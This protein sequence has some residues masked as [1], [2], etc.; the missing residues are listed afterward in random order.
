MAFNVQSW[1]RISS[2]S[3]NDI[4]TLQDGSFV[5]APNIFTYISATD[6]LATIAASGYFN[7]V[8]F[9]MNVY[10]YIQVHGTDG[11][12]ELTVATITAATPP[13]V[14]TTSAGA[15]GD[16][17]GPAVSINNNLVAFDGVT[18]KLIKD[19][20]Q[21]IATIQN[22]S[23]VYAASAAGTDTYAV[24]LA[25][26]PTAY[27]NGMVV[28]FKTDVANTGAATLNVNG[29]GAVSI[30]KTNGTALAT[31][32]IGATHIATVVYNSTGPTFQLQSPVANSVSGI[33]PLSLGGTSK[34]L[35]A[36][37]GGIV[38]SDA[39]SFEILAPTSTANQPLLSGASG[40]PGWST[41]T[42]PGATTINQ[43]LYSSAANTVGGLASANDGV[44]I[45]SAAGVPSISST[46]PSGL[47]IPSPTI[48]TPNIVGVSNASSAAAGSVGEV[49]SS[50][51]A[52]ASAVSLTTATATNITSISLTAGDWDVY[53][54]VF[55]SASVAF[56]Q[57]FCW[58]STTSATLPDVSLI[59]ALNVAATAAASAVGLSAPF[60][61]VNV[62]STTTV[63]L[64][65]W[66]TFASGT[67]TACGGIYARRVR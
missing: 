46:L 67:G 48:T 1:G 10:D 32:D 41:A 53:G 6:T 33:V 49:I 5:G 29:L 2:S 39:N 31:G 12:A 63:Y 21:S 57:S 61:R 64:G 9:E 42:Y 34:A 44:L 62:N 54:N 36:A 60:L 40:A 50:V 3:N 55:L 17:D 26:V 66:G 37:D 8:A 23:L 22:G 52:S 28:N 24:T 35:T 56:S 7:A 16:V 14:T 4:T 15:G 19:S 27:V 58:C 20:G 65:G 43:I 13:V 30:T 38:Y 45:T 59:N 25:P 47:S 51:I 11:F 18:G